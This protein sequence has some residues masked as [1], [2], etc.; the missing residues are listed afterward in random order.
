MNDFDAIVVGAGPSGVSAAL[1]MAR[2]GMNVVLLERGPYPG[3]KNLMGGVLYTDVLSRLIPDFI[4]KGAP[5]ERHVAE[6]RWSL[7]SS[8]S[9]STAAFKNTKWDKPPFNHSHTVLRARFDKWFAAQAEGEGVELVCG[10]VVDGMIKEEGRVVGVRTR[11]GEG[12]DAAEGELRAPV[13]VLC[14]GANALLAENEGLKPP[15]S[16]DDCAI[17]VKEVIKLGE[18]TI[19]E[20]FNLEG[21]QGV[22]W[23]FIGAAT[24]GLP[25]A[26]FIYTN[27]DTIS[28]G[29]VAYLG[30][31]KEDGSTPYDLL[32]TFKAHP[33]VRPLVRGGEVLE[34]GAHLIPESGVGRLP[35]RV[36]DGLMSVGDAAG[37][38]SSGPRHEGSNYA[39]ASGVMAGETALE[40]HESGDYTVS[41]LSGY[42]KAVEGSFIWKGIERY[43]QWPGFL[44][45][46]PQLFSGW[47]EALAEM[48]A[49]TLEV[50]N[51]ATG[52]AEDKLMELFNRRIGVLPFAMTALQ[53]RNSLKIF[54]YGKTDKLL[55]YISRN[56]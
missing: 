21:R 16:S 48:T 5:L 13:V 17:G 24:G 51:Y 30:E 12:T 9:A 19:A 46:N 2:G 47:P 41:G 49:S 33:A 44:K 52:E 43:S 6:K 45:Q 23:E 4:E 32:D 28:V 40:A 11:T 54:G 1:T 34:Y 8:D 35:M 18:D 56:W 36:K 50:D 42:N 53:L 14:E 3:S 20:R 22:A 55:E 29:I 27:H 10:V 7:L 39:M 37:L 38:I 15:A 26:G 31:M 25:G